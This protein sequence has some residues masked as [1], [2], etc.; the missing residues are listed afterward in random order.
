MLTDASEDY[1]RGYV[2]FLDCT[3]YLDSHPLI[4]RTETEYW[5]E[6]AIIE[7]KNQIMIYHNLPKKVRVLD[8][9]AGSGAIGVAVLK[10]VPDT[11]VDFGEIDSAHLPTIRKNILENIAD[12]SRTRILETDVW[13]NITDVYDFVLANPPY[14]SRSRIERVQKS[15][16]EHEPEKALFADDEGFALIQ[17]LIAGAKEHLTG[18]GIIYIEHE[19]EQEDALKNAARSAGFN[20]KSLTDQFGVVR[21]SRL[22]PVA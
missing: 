10:H 8:L 15:V 13:S 22:S 20:A 21:F 9:F 11:N 2:P 19:P 5:A 1:A 4:P 18:N 12:E 6:K 16:L 7:I 17:R 14:I 3:I